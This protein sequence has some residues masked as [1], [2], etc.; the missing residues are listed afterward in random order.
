[1]PS[2]PDYYALLALQPGATLEEIRRAYH[3]AARKFHPDVNRDPASVELFIQIQEAYEVLSDSRRRQEYDQRWKAEYCPPVEV[4]ILCSREAVP[5]LDEPQL[6]YALLNF[7]ATQGT[8]FAQPA[9]LNVCLVLD[10][11][12]SMQGERMDTVK[13]AAIELVRQMQPEDILSIVT[14]H[15][16][17]EV[18]VPAGTQ[19]D[20][21]LIETQIR[22][23]RPGGGTEIFQ[24]LESGFGEVRRHSNRTLVNHIIL[25]TDGRTYGDEENCLALADQAAQLGIRISGLGIGSQW[26]DIFMDEL[27]GRTGGN[28]TYISHT[29]SIRQLLQEKF[30][31]LRSA[32]AEQVTLHLEPQPG[33]T[34]SALYR[35]QP[36]AAPLGNTGPIRLGGIP[37]DDKLSILIEMVVQPFA[38]DLNQLPLFSGSIKYLL[39]SERE[40]VYQT[41]FQLTKPTTET[42]RVELP[43]PPLFHALSSVTLY[44]MQE[45]ARME[46]AEG[47]MKEASLRL[48]RL[49]TQLMAAGQIELA[50]TA[51]VEADRIQQTNTL[52]AEGSKMI[53]YGT[54][55]LLL[56]E[57]A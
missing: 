48:N 14:F 3:E 4:Q 56:P 23:I 19:Q 11:S 28:S 32:F 20:R 37:K 2:V 7:T 38:A 36:E 13:A 17:A 35:L 8:T 9:P 5:V 15:D 52:S 40:K 27:T 55:M 54:R 44:R 1:M 53:K 21:T 46:V 39:I 49:A 42:L 6:V 43:P 30:S 16:R 50:Q 24:G 12:T 26:N 51:L 10:R 41:K 33:V 18:L 29:R 31:A 57:G 25:I 45:R 47:K 22:M 34:L